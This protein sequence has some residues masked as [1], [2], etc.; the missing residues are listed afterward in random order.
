MNKDQLIA[1]ITAKLSEL[2]QLVPENK[3]LET[4][5][6]EIEQLVQQLRQV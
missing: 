4:K 2:Q 5:V 6:S 1:E 3:E